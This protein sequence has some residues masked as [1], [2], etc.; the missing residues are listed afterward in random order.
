MEY[1]DNLKWVNSKFS[2]GTEGYTIA[3]DMANADKIHE[4]LNKM[5]FNDLE[6][7]AK[8]FKKIKNKLKYGNELTEEDREFLKLFYETL[9]SC[10]NNIGHMINHV[11]EMSIGKFN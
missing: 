11:Y 6:E 7:E 5:I 3:N 4:H 10:Y 2:P 1:F 9:E 8:H